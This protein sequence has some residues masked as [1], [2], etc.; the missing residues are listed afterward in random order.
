MQER[1]ESHGGTIDFKPSK[2]G[3][4][5]VQ[6]VFPLKHSSQESGKE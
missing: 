6:V 2:E 1:A 3:G 4:L 5:E